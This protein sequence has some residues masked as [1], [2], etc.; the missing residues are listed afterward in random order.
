MDQLSETLRPSPDRRRSHR[1]AWLSLGL[2]AALT[3]AVVATMRRDRWIGHSEYNHYALQAEA[4]LHGRL[5]LGGPPPPYT[6]NNDFAVHD[7]RHFVSFPP[8]PALLLVPIV[9]AAGGAEHV[10]DGRIFALLAGAAPALLFLALE[11]LRATERSKL[12]QRHNVGLAALFGL[13]TVYWFT[14][15]QG[16]VWFAGH[17]V[18]AGFSCAYLLFALDARRPILAGA[19]LALAIGTRPSVAPL[20]VFFA[21]E[22]WRSGGRAALVRK[23]ALFAAPLVLV[24][25]ALALHNLARYGDPFEFGH[26]FLAVAWR[27]RIERFG[28]FSLQYLGRNLGVALAGMPFYSAEQGFQINGHGLALWLTSPFLLWALWPKRTSEIYWASLAS[29]LPTALVDLLYHNSGWLQFGYRFSTDFAPLLF[30][31][32]AVGARRLGFAFWL[33]AAWSVGV[34]AFGAVTFGKPEYA[35]FYF[36]D[37]TQRIVH[38][39][40]H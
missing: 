19:M 23:G 13:G 7:G 20:A 31:M 8:V 5:D 22:A 18:A 25:S 4:W 35:R 27:G 16:T 6:L 32:V 24:L 36:V 11:V 40:T 2:Y 33:L 3:V 12:G 37:H 30:V 15:A 34:N 21:V 1:S 26:R 9:A 17:V 29:A 10:A 28:L 14:A 39:P 38:Q